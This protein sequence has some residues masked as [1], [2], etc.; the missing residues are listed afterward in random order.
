MQEAEISL[1]RIR[2]QIAHEESAH[3][4]IMDEMIQALHHAVTCIDN[5]HFRILES[6]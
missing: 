1:N 3:A 2:N 4:A 6:Q 5:Y